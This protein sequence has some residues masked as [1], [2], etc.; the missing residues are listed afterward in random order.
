MENNPRI[1]FKLSNER[2]RFTP[3]RGKPL[4][5][6][7]VANLEVWPFNE[8]MPRSIFDTAHGKAEKPDLP[9][10][11]WVEYGLRCGLPRVIRALA[12]RGLPASHFMNASIPD[13]Y[14]SAADATLKAG[15]EVSGH[16]V[17]QRSLRYEDDEE[18]TIEEAKEKLTRFAGYPPRG[19]L[20]P[21]SGETMRTP[22]LLRKHGFDHVYEWQFDDLPCWMRTKYGP[23][24]AM[25]YALEVN[26]VTCLIMHRQ[27]A[28]E[29]EQRF[30]YVLETYSQELAERPRIITLALHPH[31]V[32]I[33]MRFPV[34]TRILDMLMARDDTIFMTGS[35]IVDWFKDQDPKGLKAVS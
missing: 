28:D 31:V 11:S 6:H 26:D 21:G 9:N 23:L 5:V 33:P 14:P 2:P 35:Q 13:Y 1:P 25:P 16:S 17:F 10:F 30:K 24:V 22:D 18:A 12:D 8:P 29:W 15:W 4:I 27:T 19:W 20:G 32:G 3:P 7:I 34:F